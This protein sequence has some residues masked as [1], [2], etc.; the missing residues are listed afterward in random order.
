MPRDFCIL[1][2]AF[3]QRDAEAAERLADAMVELLQ[4]SPYSEM[5]LSRIWVAHLFV[6]QALPISHERLRGLD[7][8][9]TVIGRRQSLLLYGILNDRAYFR[10]RKTKFDEASD[11]EKPALMLG[12]SCLSR[13]EYSTWL[14]TIKGHLSD[15]LEALY[16]K[17]L[18]DNQ[19]TLFEKLKVQFKVKSKSERIA[20]TFTNLDDEDTPP[21]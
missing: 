15:P 5:A 21:F 20:E 3:A 9:R 12:A 2:G 6:S 7:L 11:W 10:E 17:W 14:D 13:G 4:R 1:I 18:Q 16:R 19:A 8:A